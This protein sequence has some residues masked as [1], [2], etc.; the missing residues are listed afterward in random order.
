MATVT[1]SITRSYVPWSA[2]FIFSFMEFCM[3]IF[4]KVSV[5]ISKPHLLFTNMGVGNNSAYGCYSFVGRVKSGE[6]A[7]NL[8][9]EA[10]FAV[11][12]IMHETM[13]ALGMMIQFKI[14]RF[15]LEN[16][17]E[18]STKF[19]AGIETV[20]SRYL[21]RTYSQELN[22]TLTR[23]AWILMSPLTHHLIGTHGQMQFSL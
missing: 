9:S 2:I 11:G 6:Q 1:N 18:L 17:Q 14:G 13:H 7:V 21:L 23:R 10:C 15:F 5:D 3:N 20:T 12:I 4:S 16:F 22:R 8:G 19:S